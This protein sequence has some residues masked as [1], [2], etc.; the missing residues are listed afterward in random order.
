MSISK[1]ARLTTATHSNRRDAPTWVDAEER[2]ALN[3]AM[4]GRPLPASQRY[5]EFIEVAQGQQRLFDAD[6]AKASEEA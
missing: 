2:V 5:R 1:S 3:A 6:Q 4:R